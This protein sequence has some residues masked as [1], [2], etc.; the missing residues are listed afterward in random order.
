MSLRQKT[1]RAAAWQFAARLSDRGLRFA[2]SVVLARMLA[3]EDFGAL[4][5]V[6]VVSGMVEAITYAGVDQAIAQSPRSADPRFL[7]SAFRILA[8]R[9]LLIATGVFLAAPLVDWYYGRDDL[10]WLVRIV[11][12]SSLVAGVANPWVHSE[13]KELRLQPFSISIVAAG[14]A[15]IGV[16]LF[17][18]T[19]GFGAMALA[20]GTLAGSVA[21]T[22]TGWLLILR[23]LDITSDPEAMREL[24]S[25]AGRAAGIPFLIALFLQLPGLV[26]GRATGLTELGIFTL[27]QRLTSLPGEIALPIFGSVL[28]PAYAQIRE[29]RERLKRVWMLA[30][31]GVALLVA[32]AVAAV[33]VLDGRVPAVVYGDRYAGPAG[34]VALLAV[35]SWFSVIASCCG[36]LFWGVARPDLDRVVMAIRLIVA[37]G[38]GVF[39]TERWGAVGFAGA[40]ALAHAVSAGL[41]IHFARRIVG[42]TWGS[43]ARALAAA[44][45]AAALVAAVSHLAMRI[46]ESRGWAGVAPVAIVLA[47]AGW[48]MLV[49][50]LRMRRSV[51]G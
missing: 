46:A 28:S 33:A 32:P 13:R 35:A 4:A 15:Q 21:S 41:S 20:L 37:L 50:A 42:A 29:D 11:A 6:L 9:G 31:S 1:T 25:F 24:R 36:A 40:F 45:G 39:A 43:V 10:T 8:I 47:F 2:A 38:V 34:V 49:F 27:A 22:I 7:G 17:G 26:L 5:A 19:L 48:A 14:L 3:P 16:S 12:L 44:I 51:R 23:R 18:A 30:V